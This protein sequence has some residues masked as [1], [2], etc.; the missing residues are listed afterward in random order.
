[1]ISLESHHSATSPT[2]REVPFFRFGISDIRVHAT[3]RQIVDGVG[4]MG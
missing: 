4:W 3:V 1:M 2:S